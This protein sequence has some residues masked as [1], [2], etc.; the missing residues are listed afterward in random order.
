MINEYVGVEFRIVH[1][2]ADQSFKLQAKYSKHDHKV[3]FL[4]HSCNIPRCKNLKLLPTLVGDF[5]DNL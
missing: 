1:L 2:D 5:A 4:E 3:D